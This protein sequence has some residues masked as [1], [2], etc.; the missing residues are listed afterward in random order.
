[1]TTFWAIGTAVSTY[2]MSSNE[3]LNVYKDE[4]QPTEIYSRVMGYYSPRSRFN[5]AKVEEAKDRTYF[6]VNL[7]RP[8]CNC[9]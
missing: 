2:S 1:M 4:R 6:D 7:G 5:D 8:K 9:A 3:L